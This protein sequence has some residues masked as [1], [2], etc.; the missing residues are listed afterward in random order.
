MSSVSVPAHLLVFGTEKMFSCLDHITP[1]HCLTLQERLDVSILNNT[2]V[3]KH[4]AK[5]YGTWK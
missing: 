4:H 5:C 1:D 3:S 2:S